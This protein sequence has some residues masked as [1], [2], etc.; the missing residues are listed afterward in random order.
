MDSSA[1]L[2]AS[3]GDVPSIASFLSPQSIAVIG[4]APAEQRSIRGMLLLVLRR[5]GFKG[6]IVPVNPS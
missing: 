1:N 2:T 5:A 3:A 4:A 6:R